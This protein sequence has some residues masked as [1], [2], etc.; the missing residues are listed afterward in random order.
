MRVRLE[1]AAAVIPIRLVVDPSD[2]MDGASR[3]TFVESHVIHSDSDSD[4][5]TGCASQRPY[6][7]ELG[8]PRRTAMEPKAVEC[9][10]CKTLIASTKST[11]CQFVN[12]SNF[13]KHVK[14]C[15][16]FLESLA[17]KALSLKVQ[18]DLVGE[19]TVSAAKKGSINSYF[20]SMV[21]SESTLTAASRRKT[22]L[23]KAMM[24]L[25]QARALALFAHQTGTGYSFVTSSHMQ[26]LIETSIAIYLQNVD[27]NS[28]TC[29]SPYFP[30]RT[31]GG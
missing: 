15:R 11:L 17:F 28:Q 26:A 7:S 1:H 24:K 31:L 22:I 8:L 19:N 13:R 20:P 25:K 2:L 10:G 30:G 18:K 5:E 23:P 6:E 4:S 21:G 16:H 12:F 9:P 3:E 27:D 14:L 29:L